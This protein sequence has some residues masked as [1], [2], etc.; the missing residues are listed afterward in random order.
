MKLIKKVIIFTFILLTATSAFANTITVDADQSR[1]Y[2]IN[3]W[4]IETVDDGMIFALGE[5]T[6]KLLIIHANQAAQKG[7]NADTVTVSCNASNE[8]TYRK[9]RVEPGAELTCKGNFQDAVY[10]YTE[11]GDFKNGAQGTY[12]FQPIK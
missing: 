4:R 10:L 1:P 8:N 12:E 6:K 7:I 3:N 2:E 9:H 5:Y 11:P